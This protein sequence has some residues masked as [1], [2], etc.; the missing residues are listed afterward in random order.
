MSAEGDS[1]LPRRYADLLTDQGQARLREW[2]RVYAEQNV[3]D[4][5]FAKAAGAVVTEGPWEG[6][7]A[8]DVAYVGINPLDERVV[9]TAI[10]AVWRFGPDANGMMVRKPGGVIARRVYLGPSLPGMVVGRAQGQAP[11]QAYGL[12][13]GEEFYF[14]S[15]GE[16]WS[17]SIGGEEIHR[18]PRWYYEERY[19]TWPEAGMITEEQAYGFIAQ[20]ADRFRSGL[21]TTIERTVDRGTAS[22][23]AAID[24]LTHGG[25]TK[26]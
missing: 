17:M 6:H 26:Q 9:L 12:I 4:I 15:R 23:L 13:D 22:I 7:P 16:H 19:G 11:V 18:N 24:A 8:Q 14:R 20:A 25:S 5:E 21:P 2:T 3:E 10:C 1:S